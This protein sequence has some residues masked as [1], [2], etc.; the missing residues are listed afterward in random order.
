MQRRVANS[1]RTNVKELQDDEANWVEELQNRRNLQVLSKNMVELKEKI[2][3][4]LE[5]QVEEESAQLEKIHT[6]VEDVSFKPQ[7]RLYSSYKPRPNSAFNE[8]KSPS[9]TYRLSR[10]LLLSCPEP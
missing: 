6:E 4:P 9:G 3:P 10:A 2:I 1:K 8:P 5:K 7:I